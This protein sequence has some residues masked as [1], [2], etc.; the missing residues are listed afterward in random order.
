MK[1]GGKDRGKEGSS[2]FSILK[3]KRYGDLKNSEIL[4]DDKA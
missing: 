3:D 2:F 1:N 4:M